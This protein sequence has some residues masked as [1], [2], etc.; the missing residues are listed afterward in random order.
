M[1][2]GIAGIAGVDGTAGSGGRVLVDIDDTIIKV[3]GHAKQGA[4]FG[5]CGVRGLN[6]MLATV[7]TDQN[8][9]VIVAQRPR[10]GSTGSQRGA[11]TT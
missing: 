5:Y 10:K 6:A 2:A 11:G 7:T 9:Q 1:T 3:H 4:G 8:A